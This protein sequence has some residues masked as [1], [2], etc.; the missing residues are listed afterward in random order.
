MARRGGNPEN[1]TPYIGHGRPKGTPNRVTATIREALTYAHD[2]AGG[3]R[4]W[5][6]LAQGG[7]ED[8]RCFAQCVSRLIPLEIQGSLDAKL[9]VTI[10]KIMTLASDDSIIETMESPLL[11]GQATA[12]PL[13][14]SAGSLADHAVSIVKAAALAEGTS[15][16]T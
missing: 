2:R 5:L 3:W 12:V 14:E 10:N 4:F 9:T 16:D 6:A 11:K 15:S 7:S 1:I 8:R 13:R